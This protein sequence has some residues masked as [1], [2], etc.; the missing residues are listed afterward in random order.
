MKQYFFIHAC[1]DESILREGW[2]EVKRGPTL[3]IILKVNKGN[4]CNPM[5]NRCEPS[6]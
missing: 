6:G 5:M 4:A 3:D 1:K 2:G